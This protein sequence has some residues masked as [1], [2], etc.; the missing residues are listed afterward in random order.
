MFGGD[1]EELDVYLMGLDVSVKEY[2]AYQKKL[3]KIGVPT[4]VRFKDSIKYENFRKI[5]FI[6]FNTGKRIKMDCRQS[7]IKLEYRTVI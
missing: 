5:V 4:I 1:G 6:F 2:V 3:M 7:Y